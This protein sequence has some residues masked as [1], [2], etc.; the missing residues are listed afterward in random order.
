MRI[1]PEKF[2]DCNLRVRLGKINFGTEQGQSLVLRTGTELGD[3]YIGLEQSMGT[4]IKSQT[5]F[6]IH[7][8]KMLLSIIRGSGIILRKPK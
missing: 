1:E 2:K 5:P 3:T 7:Y 4:N 8:E 6:Q